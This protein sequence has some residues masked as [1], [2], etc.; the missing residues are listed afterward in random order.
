MPASNLKLFCQFAALLEGFCSPEYDHNFRAE[1][2]WKWHRR[3]QLNIFRQTSQVMALGVSS[4]N[5]SV[6]STKLAEMYLFYVT[7]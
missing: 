5:I 1:W 4:S 2:D 6:T 3:L 7:R